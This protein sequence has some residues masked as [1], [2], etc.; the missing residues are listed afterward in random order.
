MIPAIEVLQLL[1]TASIGT[2]VGALLT[3]GCL[4]APYW[5]SMSAE[6]FH[7]HYADLHPRLYRYFTPLTVV[8]LLL[9]LA[10]AALHTIVS[11]PV[12]GLTVAAGALTLAAA[13][14]HEV[15]FKNANSRFACA[16]LTP[17]A[18]ATELR[19]WSK[20]N[21]IRVL[22]LLVAFLSSMAALLH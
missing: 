15:Y 5:R 6:Q 13:A 2:L 3:E 9:S 8:P 12:T 1:S 16:T 4:L 10:S 7:A 19:R 17:K 14:T 22:L 18:L 20:W 21:W 11:S